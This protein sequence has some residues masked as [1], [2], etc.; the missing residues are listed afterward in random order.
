MNDQNVSAHRQFR[1]ARYALSSATPETRVL[2]LEYLLE[3]A[4]ADAQH[5]P[6]ERIAALRDRLAAIPL[7]RL[8]LPQTREILE[9]RKQTFIA[10]Y[11]IKLH[12]VDKLETNLRG[13]SRESFLLEADDL[14]RGLYGK[15]LLHRR[16]FEKWVVDLGLTVPTSPDAPPLLVG[17]SC[18]DIRDNAE[19]RIFEGA[20]VAD[21][22]VSHASFFV[23][24]GGDLFEGK[25]G[26][27]LDGTLSLFNFGLFL[28]PNRGKRAPST[29]QHSAASEVL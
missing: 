22:L 3:Q 25:R 24:T 6:A 27:G 11:G 15:N 28:F 18:R 16:E 4:P 1:A 19:M 26:Q 7:E 29:R 10:A 21:L 13:T 14:V 23:L 8:S 17:P 20:S 9:A 2:A 12:G 5:L